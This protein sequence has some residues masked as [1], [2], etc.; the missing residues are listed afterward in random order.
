MKS[1][2]VISERFCREWRF[3][4]RRNTVCLSS[5]SNCTVGAKD[6]LRTADDFIIGYPGKGADKEITPG[7]RFS[8]LPG[9]ISW[10]SRGQSLVNLPFLDWNTLSDCF[11]NCFRFNSWLVIPEKCMSSEEKGRGVLRISCFRKPRG[12]LDHW[13]HLFVPR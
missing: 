3:E 6:P 12:E 2:R 7:Q 4:K 10:N 13:Y 11:L 5:F 8:R 9:V 1:A